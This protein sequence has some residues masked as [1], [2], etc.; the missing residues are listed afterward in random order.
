MRA[1]YL[2][3]PGEG[4]ALPKGLGKLYMENANDALRLAFLLTGDRATSEDVVQDA[5][6]RVSGRLAHLRDP[7]AF[8]AYLHRTVVRLCALHFRRRRREKEFLRRNLPIADHINDP[9][10]AE[11]EDLR[12]ALLGLPARQRAAIVLRYYEQ[13][14]EVEIASILGCRVGTVGSLISRGLKALRETR[15]EVDD[16]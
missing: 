7:A 15:W 4:Q 10:F 13:I 6:L 5:F 12:R 14:P 16:A 9:E 11:L 8:G 3:E 2:A 1:D